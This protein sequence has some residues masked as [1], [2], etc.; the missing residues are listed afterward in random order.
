VDFI[1]G[2]QADGNLYLVL[3]F[4]AGGN[5]SERLAGLPGAMP[6]AEAAGIMLQALDGMAMAHFGVT[7]SGPVLTLTTPSET[8]CGGA[9]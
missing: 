2:G 7:G 5:L 1:A 3:E 8:P 6:P 9:I 4:M